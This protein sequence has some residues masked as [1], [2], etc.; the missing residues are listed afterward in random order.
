MVRFSVLALALSA[1]VM[2]APAQEPEIKPL[3]LTL[4]SAV[5]PAPAL[6][7]HFLPERS[8][9]SPGNAIV[10]YNRAMLLAGKDVESEHPMWKWL[11]MSPGELPREEVRKFL[12]GYRNM[13]RELDLA[14]RCEHCDWQLSRQI[15][16]DGFA[17]L[18][19]EIQ[20]MR[21]FANFL[22]LK[23]RFE[24]AEGKFDQG[25]QTLQTGFAM[26][27]HVNQSP[28]LISAL[29]SAAIAAIM[30][31]Q[32][33]L[34]VQM[35][36]APDLYWA[37]TSLPQPFIDI[38]SSMESER[39]WV[40]G[41]F[42]ALREFG[43]AARKAPLSHEELQ[44]ALTK[45][46]G[47][48]G[49]PARSDNWQERFMFAGY[50]A[51]TYPEARRALLGKGWTEDQIEAT[52]MLQ[53]VMLHEIDRYDCAFDDMLKYLS[54]P[55]WQAR[56]EQLKQIQQMKEQRSSDPLGGSILANLLL[57]AVDK[58]HFTQ[59]RVDRKIAALRTIEAIRFY[60]ASHEGH[61]PMQ[62]EDIKDL[63]IPIDPVTGRP[64]QYTLD[65][66]TATLLCPPPPGEPAH[67]G[68]VLRYS[69]QMSK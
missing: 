41:L 65:G 45:L 26:A 23:A 55:Y 47:I 19:P 57:P 40:D 54:L 35:P 62:L 33:D 38:R 8:E 46:L 4:H 18:L 50:A 43:P 59:A 12:D 67:Q 63:P 11:E 39:V 9:M 68:T 42:P 13:Y 10:N 24:V 51:R 20:R 14:A 2:A 15:R 16:S 31:N 56:P 44:A 27:R 21:T 69:L 58:I 17:L 30:L 5:M 1:G 25:V 53:V 36:G 22:A 28:T 32:V 37:L 60:A 34:L 48:F 6:K 3:T 29:V 61:M 64:L 49:S 66:A 52:P 7:Y